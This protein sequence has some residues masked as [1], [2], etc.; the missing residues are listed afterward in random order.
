MEKES[1]ITRKEKDK[2]KYPL[3]KEIEKDVTE[4]AQLI[5]ETLDNGTEREK[6]IARKYFKA[7][8]RINEICVKRNRF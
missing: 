7:I 6:E 5:N 2:M 3:Q 4:S 1:F 8:T